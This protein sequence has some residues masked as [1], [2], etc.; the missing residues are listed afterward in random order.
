MLAL[1]LIPF[2]GRK[3]VS[4][5]GQLYGRN[6]LVTEYLW[7]CHWLLHPPQPGEIVPVGKERETWGGID[8]D[9]KDIPHL[10]YRGRKQVS[11]HIQV[12]KQFFKTHPCCEC[13]LAAV[14]HCHVLIASSSFLL[15]AQDRAE[16]R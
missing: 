9:G 7:I 15:P 12:L 10:F 8:K 11:S 6:M 3:K 4:A 14:K 5:K 2:M 16:G 1:L 13:N